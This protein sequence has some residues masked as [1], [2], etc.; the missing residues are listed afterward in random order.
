[1]KTSERMFEG[2]TIAYKWC[3]ETGLAEEG[4]VL[5]SLIKR[6]DEHD[7]EGHRK[8]YTVML[9]IMRG[10]AFPRR[11]PTQ[12]DLDLEALRV[13]VDA[14]SQAEWDII[15]HL[16]LKRNRFEGTNSYSLYE[17]MQDY[18]DFRYTMM[19]QRIRKMVNDE[20]ATFGRNN[21]GKL[22]LTII[23]EEE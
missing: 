8:L 18:L 10:H 11:M 9:E 4:L 7:H 3:L 5:Q 16:A 20:I 1:M 22:V 17:N 6:W 15:G 21:D 19:R 23:Q 14:A 13:I 2:M 12:L